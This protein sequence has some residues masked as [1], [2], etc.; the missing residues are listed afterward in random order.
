MLAGMVQNL[1]HIRHKE[2]ILR[3]SEIE[4]L[5]RLMIKTKNI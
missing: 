4:T 5:I 2:K 1:K 3:L